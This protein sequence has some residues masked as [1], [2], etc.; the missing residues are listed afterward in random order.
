MLET[1]DLSH[2]PSPTLAKQAFKP[3]KHEMLKRI[4]VLAQLLYEQERAAIIV[5]EG[6]DAAGKGTTIRALIGRLDARGYK[7][8]STQAPRT[9]EK[10]KPWLWR[11]W[12]NIPRHGQIAIFDRSWYGRVL[13]E[14]VRGLTPIPAWIAAY[15]EIN[16]FERTLADDGTILLKFWLHIGR[17]E[18]LRR[19][20]ALS[21]QPET[22]WQVTAEDWENHRQYGDYIP[23][24]RDM[25]ASTNTAYAP[26]VAIAATDREYRLYSV[27]RSLIAR[28]E[29]ALEVD[30]TQWPEA[31]ELQAD[32]GEEGKKSKKKAKDKKAK[33]GKHKSEEQGADDENKQTGE[34]SGAGHGG[35]EH[36]EAEHSEE[37]DHA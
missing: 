5:F 12:M 22:A 2:T 21:R 24:M 25:L 36:S 20:I 34:H 30:A 33:K 13:V 29:Q 4:A 31:E 35:A 15:E 26:W 8:L 19:F 7:V 37:A 3:V 10:Q 11:F 14:R 23:A 28:L 32:S 9:N 17:E 18:Q 16:Q 6:W 1:L 27:C